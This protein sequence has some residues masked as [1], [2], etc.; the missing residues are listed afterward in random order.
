M[1]FP[2][3]LFDSGVGGLTVLSRLLQRHREVSCLYLADI[4]RLPYGEKQPA[5][6]REIAEE[7]ATWLS[8]QK[9]SAILMA[10]NTTNSL[11]FDVVKKYSEVPVFGLVSAAVE[12]IPKGKRIGVLATSATTASGAYKAQIQES[13]PEIFVLEQ[14]CPEFVPLIEAGKV[15]GEE[16]RYKAIKYVTPLLDAN[17]DVVVLGCTH[18]PLIMPLLKQLF[19][20]EVVFLDPAVGLVK[21]IDEILGFSK[22]L[23]GSAFSLASTRFCVTS[24]PSG[25][26]DRATP[27]LGV[28][29][30]VELV[31]LRSKACFF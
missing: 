7:V 23:S 11:A 9:V 12:M 21:Q 22:P 4:A 15:G 26:A 31:S 28:R 30:E 29:P 25:F 20:T 3:G 24:D 13:H 10:C 2:L 5:E 8:S 18:Y 6:I 16:L 27:W 19:P 1:S 17:V 14:A